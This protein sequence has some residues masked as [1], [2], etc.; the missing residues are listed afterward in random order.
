MLSLFLVVYG[1]IVSKFDAG[2]LLK[3]IIYWGCRDGLVF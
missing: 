1:R 2:F 3:D